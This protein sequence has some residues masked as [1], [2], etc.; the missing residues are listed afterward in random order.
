VLTP[1]FP[2][3]RGGI[4]ILLHRLVSGLS[5]FDTRVVTLARE[6]A[7]AFDA[8][9]G[10]SVRRVAADERLGAGRNIPLNLAALGEARSFRPHVTLSAHIVTSPAAA[11]ARRALGTRTVQYFYAKEI[12]DKPRLAAFAA[13]RADAGISISSYT[14]ELLRAR[15]ASPDVL[16]LIPPGVDLPADGT[17]RAPERPTFLTVSRLADRYKGHDV[18]VRAL[19]RVRERVPDVEWIVIGDGP[20]RGEIEQLARDHGVAG[21]IR[22]LGAVGDEQRDL[23][24]RHTNLLAMPS[25]LPE[26]RLAGEG[27]G[28]VYLEAGA[29]GKPVVAGNVAGALDAVIEGK[30]GLL[31]DPRD[32]EAVSDAITRL[33]L[34][35][36]L[37]ARFGAAGALRAREFSWPVMVERVGSLLREQLAR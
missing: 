9:S 13:R 18:L 35:P 8:E 32:P 5:D 30:T 4:Q 20:L 10:I 28:I 19:V 34:D 12:G 16:R 2:P 23:W 17:A 27:F 22:F 7:A 33:L 36:A 26:G 21:S 24:L 37:A 6:G 31:V 11:V 1:D 29:Y 25:R 3:G 15:A 14:S